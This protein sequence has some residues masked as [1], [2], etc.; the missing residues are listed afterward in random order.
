MGIILDWTD[1]NSG[2]RQEDEVRI[3]RHIAAFDADSLPAILATLPADTVTYDDTATL[4]GVSYW[5]AVAYEKNGVLAMDFTGEVVATGAADPHL[6]FVKFI[7]NEW[8]SL[9]TAEYPPAQGYTALGTPVISSIVQHDGLDTLLL[10]ATNA[11]QLTGT[12][13]T[14]SIANTTDFCMEAWVYCTGSGLVNSFFNKRDGGGAEEFTVGFTATAFI[15]LATF[16]S[17]S[18]NKQVLSNA[19]V[20]LSTWHHIAVVRESSQLRMYVNGVVQTDVETETLTPS[21][22]ATA[23]WLGND[24]FNSTRRFRGNFG[25]MRITHGHHRYDSDFTPERTFPTS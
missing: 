17:G 21:A 18:V 5:Y 24:V 10:N 3:Y 14:L 6:A 7:Q 12:S 4:G 20:A 1:P 2:I 16:R 11:L 15:E 13:S 25:P 8:T 19:A 9:T 22:N 23:V